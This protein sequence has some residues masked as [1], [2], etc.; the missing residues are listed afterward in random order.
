MCVSPNRVHF[1]K[2]PKFEPVNVPCG[3]CWACRQ[4]RQNDLAAKVLM[5]LAV[6]EWSVYLTL[7]YGDDR[8][9][10]SE[11]YAIKMIEKE[12][13]RNFWRKVKFTE[14]LSAIRGVWCGEYGSKKGRTHFHCIMLG[15]GTKPE[16][17]NFNE[18]REYMPAWPYG[19]VYAEPVHRQNIE[20]VTKY[21]TFPDHPKRKRDNAAQ[22]NEWVN[23]SKY[24]PLGINYVYELAAQY[25]DEKLMPRDFR[26]NPPGANRKKRY[27]ISGVSQ[28]LFLQRLYELW[29]EAYSSP[30]KTEIMKN[31]HLRFIKWEQ[32]KCWDSM[33]IEARN[34]IIFSEIRNFVRLGPNEH[35]IKLANGEKCIVDFGPYLRFFR[36]HDEW[37]EANRH[38]PEGE[39]DPLPPEVRLS[40]QFHNSVNVANIVRRA[41]DFPSQSST[42]RE[43]VA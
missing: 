11:R 25:A 16:L 10:P 36:A 31:A 19:F 33:S 41:P 27:Q 9:P 34:K 26:V 2:G 40:V 7:T 12:H 32:K 38:R 6:S 17:P 22:R 8:T 15:N 30:H 28:N 4:N 13:F 1:Q 39:R 3:K 35:E 18:E 42:I 5:E 20:Y 37:L 43:S 14:G 23:Y 24:P 29:P 21:L